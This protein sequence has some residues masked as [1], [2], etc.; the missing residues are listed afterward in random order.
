MSGPT[1]PDQSAAIGREI[2]IAR[3]AHAKGDIAAALKT[4]D[5]ILATHPDE[6][7]ALCLRG[8]IR[9]DSGDIQAAERDFRRAMSAAPDMPLTYQLL[10]D[11]LHNAKHLVMAA[12]IY[13]LGLRRDPGNV[14]ILSNLAH[15]RLGLGHYQ[16]SLDLSRR[17]VAID[18]AQ[19][20]AWFRIGAS[21]CQLGDAAS[22]LAPLA[23]AIA[24]KPDCLRS[25]AAL[26]VA[27]HRLADMAKMAEDLAA[28][29]IYL[30]DDF[31]HL[32]QFNEV[33]AW[34]NC[35][36]IA[37]PVVR[38]FLERH[39]RDAR[40]WNLLAR[41]HIVAGEERYANELLER[42]IA[43]AP[44]DPELHLTLG[45]QQF[46]LGDFRAG[47][48]RYRHRW[49][50]PDMSAREGK[51]DIAA[52]AWN[53]QVLTE[54]TLMV[55]TEQGIG[56]LA[57]FAGFFNDLADLAPRVMIET[58]GR[59]RHLLQR[60]F[61]W[62][63]TYQRDQLPPDFIARND[64]KAHVP[65]GDL[66]LLLGADFE[67]LPAR[68]GYLIPDA[69]QMWRLR[70][71]YQRRFPGRLIVG[72]S[73]RSGN[74]SSAT[75]R[76]AELD[77]WR[78]LLKDPRFGFVSLQYGAVGEE[79]A[80]FNAAAGADIL[81][82][83]EVD[84]LQDLDLFAAQVAAVDLVISVDNSTVHFAGAMGKRVW[85]LLPHVADWRW[86][87]ERPESIWYAKA[88]L[89]RQPK[90]DDWG[91]V[92]AEVQQLLPLFDARLARDDLAAL[93]H[94]CAS[95]LS[96]L[97]NSSDA[98]IFLRRL[99]QQ[100]D[101][102]V[103]ALYELGHLALATGHVAD[104]I[105]FLARGA[106]IAPARI[107]IAYDLARGRSELPNLT[108]GLPRWVPGDTS[109]RRLLLWSD[110]TAAVDL[111]A[112]AGLPAL[113]DRC[114]LLVLGVT[115]S[116]LP[117]FARLDR[118]L[119]LYRQEDLTAG[120]MESLSLDGQA[121]LADLRPTSMPDRPWLMADPARVAEQRAQNSA[122]F[123]DRLVVGLVSRQEGPWAGTPMPNWAS[124]DTGFLAILAAQ[125]SI[126]LVVLDDP[127]TDTWPEHV[128]TDPRLDFRRRS[129]A[130]AAAIAAVDVVV[131]V[132]SASAW[133]AAALGKRLFL[134]RGR[135]AS[136]LFDHLSAEV[137]LRQSANGSWAR[138][139][140]E[141]LAA[142]AAIDRS[143]LQ[144]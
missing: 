132:E 114:D 57:M 21:L 125:T 24:L 39:P 1:A 66:P 79:V 118:R 77:W 104:G 101:T 29:E 140:T 94:R 2:E 121:C 106:A 73:W 37:F 143:I 83:P 127:G 137:T 111:A 130:F 70:E 10:G 60:S 32:S 5:R 15:T 40:A 89:F 49:D 91:A 9:R 64:I 67:R 33:V 116:L 38:A 19:Q 107:D 72:I 98:E 97:G 54:G 41:L 4:Y 120:D 44:D 26:C 113:R 76:S 123:G 3:A 71:R 139:L 35:A 119:T 126:G 69:A 99:L 88:R 74:K 93:M 8:L 68:E 112:A 46:K 31:N 36:E 95:Q 25:R 51:W 52:P 142:L 62:A 117:L 90:R 17:V 7:R 43:L 6:A 133:L 11:L 144:K 56:D 128:R 102:D 105:P 109:R 138:A 103:D 129:D 84:P 23:R 50:R 28:A 16:A 65:I 122:M 58:I 47:L 85:I 20:E 22:A 110:G 124:L 86:L 135:A 12:D 78:D 82:D 80:A 55:W 13:E 134:L 45:L 141:L 59:F 131:A 27:H 34:L 87:T 75:T 42:A 48:E 63:Q 18:P 96:Y 92:F 61:P 14:P 30:A 108:F 53:G 115:G 100:D 81:C 136:S